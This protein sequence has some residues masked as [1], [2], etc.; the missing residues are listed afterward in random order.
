[1]AERKKSTAQLVELECEVEWAKVFGFNRDKSGPD[2]VWEETEGRT[3]VV[4][5][6]SQ[7]QFKH[8]KS[9]GVQKQA[10][11]VDDEGRIKVQFTRKW[12]DKFPN[13][14]GAPRVL[15]ADGSEFNTEEQGL[16]GNGTKAIVFVS[17][18]QAGKHVGTRLEGLQVL[19]LVEYVS[20][21]PATESYS[22]VPAIDRTKKDTTSYYEVD[23][24]G[25]NTYTENTKQ[26]LD[27]EIPF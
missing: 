7:A 26:E 19:D 5:M 11:N 12:I 20:D 8:L 15:N 27:D 9:I 16:I 18:Y 22:R 17:V 10:K 14:G 6:L 25:S 4:A 13:W 23:E 3:S 2:G 1:M 24:K 21:K